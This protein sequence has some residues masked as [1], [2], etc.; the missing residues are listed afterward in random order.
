MSKLIQKYE[1]SEEALFYEFEKFELIKGGEV[2]Q[3][4]SWDVSHFASFKSCQEHPDEVE[5]KGL[6]QKKKNLM[7][8]IFGHFDLMMW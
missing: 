7:F 5:R 4:P 8:S 6:S 1:G 3:V 2:F